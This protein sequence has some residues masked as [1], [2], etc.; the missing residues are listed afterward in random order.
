[1]LI[2]VKRHGFSFW[3]APHRIGP[4]FVAPRPRQSR[5]MKM[6]TRFLAGDPKLLELRDGNWQK[7]K[8]V[9][10]DLFDANEWGDLVWFADE[11]D[12]SD[13]D[14]G[15]DRTE[16]QAMTAEQRE[17]IL[18]IQKRVRAVFGVSE[19]G[20][21]D[22]N[23]QEAAW[24]RVASMAICWEQLVGTGVSMGEIGKLHNGR[25]HAA[26]C[27]A[28]KRCEELRRTSG[29]FAAALAGV[30]ATLLKKEAA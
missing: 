16:F 4:A 30:E 12:R 10:G 29:K 8:P 5:R 15:L 24:A 27:R 14:G 21:K 9:E 26:V 20:F 23:W 11:P 2:E 28:V 3:E 17:L 19:R 7:A 18:D 1:M 22:R 6:L 25:D 13:E